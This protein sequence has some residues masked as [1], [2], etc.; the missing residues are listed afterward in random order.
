M[1]NFSEKREQ[2]YSII[3]KPGFYEMELKAEWAQT[4]QKVDY[5]NCIF[6]VRDDVNQEFQGK[7]VYDG[8]YKQKNSDEFN[9]N[10]IR[11]ILE[12]QEN[13]KFD[14]EDY[15][16]LIQY[17]NGLLLKAE[18][19]IEE[20]DDKVPNSKRRNTIKYLSYGKSKFPKK[21]TVT[22]TSRFEEKKDDVDV[23][24]SDELPF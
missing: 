11:A 6:T 5:I 12:T 13:P 18:V 10:K 7:F 14:F 3:E 23:T 19:V 17:L 15:D 4:N 21:L 16:E 8:I 9:Y 2:T 1:L 20:A 24:F 22:A